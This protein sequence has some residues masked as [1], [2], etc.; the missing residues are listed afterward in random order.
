MFF[1]IEGA[2]RS[3][4]LF[5]CSCSCSCSCCA[6][7]RHWHPL[8]PPLAHP[9]LSICRPHITLFFSLSL[10][11]CVCVSNSFSRQKAKSSDDPFQK[12]DECLFLDKKHCPPVRIYQKGGREKKKKEGHESRLSL[13]APTHRRLLRLATTSTCPPVCTSRRTMAPPAMLTPVIPLMSRT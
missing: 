4:Y 8:S 7:F 5:F 2:P 11:V 9:I 13:F 1:P 3:M 12:R 6:V 10:H